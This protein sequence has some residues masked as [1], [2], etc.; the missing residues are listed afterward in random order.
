[1]ENNKKEPD[2]MFEP[3]ETPDEP[4]AE[5]SQAADEPALSEK[6]AAAEADAK[7]HYDRYLRLA[8][9]FDNYKKRTARELEDFRKF[10][11]EKLLKALL[12][13]VDNLELAVGSAANDAK[14]KQSIV[15]GV[16]LTLKEVFK[17]FE[18]FGVQPIDALGKPFDPSFHQ[19]VLREETDTQPENTVIKEFQKGYLLNERLLRPAMVVV[20][21]SKAEPGSEPSAD[22]GGD[23]KE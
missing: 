8:A 13:V 1:M 19:A 3:L 12:P 7:E 2:K 20:A 23:D 17:I 5:A 4:R 18:Q 10:S 15:E 22:S 16:D 9:E 11:N 14:D 21:A 6:L